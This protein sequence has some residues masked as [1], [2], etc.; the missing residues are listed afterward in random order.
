MYALTVNFYLTKIMQ[1]ILEQ[2]VLYVND[3]I[4][5]LVTTEAIAVILPISSLPLCSLKCSDRN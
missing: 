4:Y 3:N 1:V 2:L 5:A